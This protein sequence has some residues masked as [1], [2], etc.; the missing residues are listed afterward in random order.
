MKLVYQYMAIFF[1]FSPTSNHRHPLQV[2]NCV[3]DEDDN[4]KSGLKGLRVKNL[5]DI[6]DLGPRD[7]GSKVVKQLLE[8]GARCWWTGPNASVACRLLIWEAVIRQSLISRTACIAGC[9]ISVSLYWRVVFS[10]FPTKYTNM[11]C[12]IVQSFRK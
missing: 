4:V 10:F 7:L 8:N 3:V 9:L 12:L 6:R 5:P 1:T 2:E 11:S